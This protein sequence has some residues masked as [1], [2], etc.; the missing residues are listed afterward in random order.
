[1]VVLLGRVIT[2]S[3]GRYLNTRQHKHRINA[4]TQNIN[5]I[6]G[7]RTH[8]PSVRASEDNS[9]LRP[10]GY[11]EL[12]VTFNKKRDKAIPVRSRRGP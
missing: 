10:Q 8:D 5:V 2:L 9:R 6:N 4:N 3:Q 7:I 12:Y 11:C 1:M